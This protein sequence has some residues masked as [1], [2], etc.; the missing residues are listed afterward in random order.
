[1]MAATA[2][3][4][5]VRVDMAKYKAFLTEG[6]SRQEIETHLRGDALS[7]DEIT[8]FWQAMASAALSDAA[9][10]SAP[11]DID[12][13][14]RQLEPFQYYQR[15]FD[16]PP[17]PPRKAPGDLRVVFISDTHSLHGEMPPIPDGDILVHGGDFTD[18]GDRDEVAAFNSFLGTLPHRYKV[19]I[20]GNHECTFDAPYYK[21]HWARYGHPMPYDSDMVRASLT[22]ALYLEDALVSVE[23]YRL[24]GCVSPPLH[25]CLWAHMT[26]SSPWQP[27]FCNWAF[28]LPRGSPALQ[29]KWTAIPTDVD[30]LLTHTPPFGRGDLVGVT[31]VGDVHLLDQVQRRIKPAFHLFG[32][33]HEGYGS[34]CDG[35]TIFINGSNCTDEYKAI[36]P[37]VVFDLPPR[38]ATLVDDATDYHTLLAAQQQHNNALK[39][40][41]VKGTSADQ[42]FEETLRLRP[43]ASPET[44]AMK[45]CFRGHTTNNRDLSRADTAPPGAPPSSTDNSPSRRPP[46]YSVAARGTALSRRIT[47]G[48][49]P[50]DTANGFDNIGGA[51]PS[52]RGPPIRRGLGPKRAGLAMLPEENEVE[53]PVVVV[54]SPRATT[55][56]ECILCKLH[57]P[58]HVHPS[59]SSPPPAASSCAPPNRLTQATPIDD[60]CIMCKMHVPGHVHAGRITSVPPSPPPAQEKVSPADDDPA[61]CALCK[62]KVPGHVHPGRVP[63]EAATAFVVPTNAEPR[64]GPSPPASTPDKDDLLRRGSSWF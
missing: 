64:D 38:M 43:V 41:C 51:A 3:V 46:N 9:T 13:I 47:M 48:V 26:S 60:D 22:N 45:Y 8:S 4:D 61:A 34:S 49:L 44:R 63:Q 31:H 33:V 24:Y 21:T 23:G 28:N 27:E 56:N 55:E 52:M 40:F 57:V 20:G 54:V 16:L 58:G 59:A 18:T 11:N 32:H 17:V 15:G 53:P 14:W 29:A 42:L 35:T 36:N 6:K 1:M 30:I 62:Y 5:D 7:A 37:I 2:A 12:K 25:V 19:V 10:A 39:R 50:Q